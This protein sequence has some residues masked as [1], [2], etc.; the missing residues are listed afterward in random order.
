MRDEKQ[1]DRPMATDGPFAG[2]AVTLPISIL[3]K[4]ERE[5]KALEAAGNKGRGRSG[6]ITAILH[7]H[8]ERQ[9]KE[10]V[11]AA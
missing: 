10:A 1:A 7:E 4:I 11:G 3:E 2:V 6:V 9:E 8:Y 5:R